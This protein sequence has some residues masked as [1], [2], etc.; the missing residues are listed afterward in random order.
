MIIL[1]S[2]GIEQKKIKFMKIKLMNNLKNCTSL[3][4]L[5]KA[6]RKQYFIKSNRSKIKHLHMFTTIAHI[7]KIKII[8]N[9]SLNIIIEFC[10]I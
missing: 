6:L 4:Q 10:A 9:Y 5:T 2:L 1:A 3:T 7:F 8:R